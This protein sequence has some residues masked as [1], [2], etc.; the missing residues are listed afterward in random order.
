MNKKTLPLVKPLITCYTPVA[1]LFSIIGRSSLA[2]PWIYS[3]YINI[4]G[5]YFRFNGAAEL[6]IIPSWHAPKL[7][8]WI[9]E[10]ILSR[11]TCMVFDESIVGFLQKCIDTDYYVYMVVDESKFNHQKTE[12]Y[13]PHDLFISGYD[14]AKEIFYVH[15][16][17]L[18]DFFTCVEISFSQIDDAYK[19]LKPEDDYINEKFGGITLWKYNSKANYDFDSVLV[20]QTLQEY[21]LSTNYMERFRFMRNTHND[22]YLNIKHGIGVYEFLKEVIITQPGS[23]P[24]CMNN[25]YD[26]KSLMVHRLNYMKNNNLLGNPDAHINNYTKIRDEMKK[27]SNL[28]I[29][30]QFT[31]DK[32][33]LEKIT[34]SL[35][36]LKAFE[37]DTVNTIIR[38]IE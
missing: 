10:S 20:K 13:F 22:R 6:A 1:A 34:S 32:R 14:K 12:S 38:S 18:T 7:C 9:V 24:K 28:A 30:Y 33:L 36:Q 11:E 35:D 26:H 31:K 25:F 16:F 17:A 2:N 19:N 27:N 29:K 4:T 8:P 15:D 5:Y 23:I 3:N 37:I 21:I